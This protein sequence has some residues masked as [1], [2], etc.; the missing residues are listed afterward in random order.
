[1][2]E[3]SDE[4]GELERLAE[5]AETEPDAVSIDTLVAALRRDP[6]DSANQIRRAV[7]SLIE[8]G[9]TAPGDAAAALEPLTA[10]FEA[11]AAVRVAFAS[12][13]ATHPERVEGVTPILLDA[14]EGGD[15]DARDQAFHALEAL[16]ETRPSELL[17]EAVPALRSKLRAETPA[18]QSGALAVTAELARQRPA[19]VTPVTPDLLA[20]VT[21]EREFSTDDEY[22]EELPDQ[23]KTRLQKE[24]VRAI[25][26]RMVAA[27][28]LVEITR[29]DVDAGVGVI[30]SLVERLPDEGNLTVREATYDLVWLIG[31]ERPTAVRSAV[32]PLAARLTTEGDPE[33]QGKIARALGI[34]ADDHQE[35]VVTA[36]SSDVSTLCELLDADEPVALG[37]A[38]GLLSY[39]AERWPDAVEP[40]VPRLREL[41]ADG[42]T[43]VRGNAIWALS[44]VGGDAAAETLDEVAATAADRDVRAIATEARRRLDGA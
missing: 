29:A 39:L 15:P 12:L 7:R 36:V 20:L 22:F 33:I 2:T 38:V 34:L 5:R 25:R 8:S 43:Y 24:E 21:T 28:A 13:V 16:A 10:D 31:Q 11:A 3:S 26:T 14:V 37:G 18:E 23:L 4:V 6:P 32:E 9:P 35:A 19:A 17:P 41:A 27:L 42:P 44:Y 1:M 30:E 40:A